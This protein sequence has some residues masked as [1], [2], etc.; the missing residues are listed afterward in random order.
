M[1][2]KYAK[3]EFTRQKERNM[4]LVQLY[5]AAI[6]SRTVTAERNTAVYCIAVTQISTFVFNLEMEEKLREQIL[7]LVLNAADDIQND[8]L[9]FDRVITQAPYISRKDKLQDGPWRW[10]QSVKS[11]RK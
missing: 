8:I 5:L 2:F 6:A 11:R 3:K 4:R 10:V 7:T 9:L 1:I